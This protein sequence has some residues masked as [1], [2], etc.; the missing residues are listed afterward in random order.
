MVLLVTALTIGAGYDGY[1]RTPAAG[2]EK[3]GISR[4]ISKTVLLL[5]LGISLSANVF[6]LQ[7][8][9]RMTSSYEKL[10]GE[11]KVLADNYRDLVSGLDENGQ[12]PNIVPEFA[13]GFMDNV[14]GIP[15]RRGV[16]S[17]DDRLT[18]DIEVAELREGIDI[19]YIKEV[20][21]AGIAFHSIHTYN[22]KKDSLPADFYVGLTIFFRLDGVTHA[23]VVHYIDNNG[24]EQ[25]LVIDH[26]KGNESIVKL[27]DI[28]GV[29][30]T[31]H[32]LFTDKEI[33]VKFPAASMESYNNKGLPQ[34]YLQTGRRP[35]RPNNKSD[36]LD[37]IRDDSLYGKLI[38]P[39]TGDKSVVKIVFPGGVEFFVLVPEHDLLPF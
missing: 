14:E 13:S 37:I 26:G 22:S 19:E 16:I 34:N 32:P 30:V 9:R 25:L 11:T 28:E 17:F 35:N 20:R 8:N 23:G 27:S 5:A 36:L 1:A 7:V 15:I 4:G 24:D 6:Q 12:E 18:P 21:K 2:V 38:M 39:S 29:L 3:T 31:R 10:V 33:D